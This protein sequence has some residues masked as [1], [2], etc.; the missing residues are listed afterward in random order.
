MADYFTEYSSFVGAKG[1]PS[2]V[3]TPYETPNYVRSKRSSRA[4]ASSSREQ[5]SSPPPLPTDSTDL[6][7]KTRDGRYT[8]LDPR[9]FTPTLHASLVSEILNLRR[10]LDSKNNLVENLE[11]DLS[12]ARNENE[13]LNG[14][15]SE[16]TKEIRRAKHQVQQMEQG[17]YDAVEV[18][19]RERDN[20]LVALEEL[21][22]KLEFA[23]RKTKQQDEDAER[24]QNIWE[25]DKESW[26]NERRQ[27]ERRIHVTESRLRAV[28]DEMS[29]QQSQ[30]QTDQFADDLVFKDS[31]LGEGSDTASI[32]SFNSPVKHKRNMSSISYRPRNGR[33]SV[34]SRTTAATPDL[35]A[36]PGGTLADELGID[37]EEE[38]ELENDGSEQGD[39]DLDVAEG[40]KRTLRSRQSSVAGDGDLD[41]KSKRDLGLRTDSQ[42]TPAAQDLPKASSETQDLQGPTKKYLDRAT[43]PPPAGFDVTA[44]APRAAYVDSGYQPSPPASPPRV[45]V[46]HAGD[47]KAESDES[48]ANDEMRPPAIDTSGLQ[49]PR[50]EIPTKPISPP[51]TPVV[52]GTTW[53]HEKAAFLVALPY[54]TASTQTDLVEPEK[55]QTGH[56]SKRD[57]LSPPMFVPSIAIIPPS[58]RPSS[59]RPYVLP[60]G[61]K[62]AFSQANLVWPSKD[63]CAQTEEIRIDKRPV[64]LPPHLL[65]GA[66]LPS[67]TF[68]EQARGKALVMGRTASL[69]NKRKSPPAIIIPA[70]PPLQS[71]I[72]SSPEMS[73]NNSAKDLRSYPLKALPLPRPVLSPLLPPIESFTSNGPLNRSS[74]YGVTQSR[75]ELHQHTDADQSSDGSDDEFREEHSMDVIPA[76]SRPPLGRFGLSDPPKAVPE[77]KEISPERRPSTADSYGAAPAPSIS[78]SRAAS[79]RRPARQSAMGSKPNGNRDFRSRSPSFGSM[80]SSHSAH[81]VMP[82]PP[83]PV[84]LRTSS[85]IVGKPLSEGSQSPTPYD[86][87]SRGGRSGRMNPT[88]QVSLRKVQSAAVMRNRTGRGSPTKDRFGRASPTRRSSPSKGYRRQRRS[89]DLTPVQS[90]AFE[91][92]AP[93]KFPIPELPTPLQDSLSYNHVNGSVDMTRSP[94]RNSGARVSEETNLVDAIAGTMV[95]EWMWKYIRKRKSFG[96]SDDTSEFPVA[97]QNGIVSNTGHGTRH[98]RWVWLSPYERTIMWDTKQ[99]NSGAALLGKKGRKRKIPQCAIILRVY[100]NHFQLPFNLCSMWKTVP[101]CPRMQSLQLLGIAPS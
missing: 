55:P 87:F 10:E 54:S 76:L 78:S 41:A 80:G 49:Q 12:V 35:Y 83:F 29:L 37:E 91:S 3:D 62:N 40:A 89:P 57:S 28:V 93:T 43:T 69:F 17:T 52:D 27:L 6:Q 39:E 23:Q 68:Q 13:A 5:S 60:P 67:P 34:S 98:K 56:T 42:D 24:T 32:R 85:R 33:T 61:T 95:G 63:A 59:P 7:D 77:D 47:D 16:N 97:D 101:H 84:P 74:Q 73:R 86:N 46:T 94:G 1:M 66:L 72:E 65:P 36:R 90:L 25:N 70:S 21:R 8:G 31:G 75:I 96:I 19:A 99:P 18:L 88:R 15:L 48:D 82:M 2:P 9:R 11:S 79:Q 22:S 64:K 50:R 58:S 51:Q 14:Q 30:L 53:L 92:P 45:E 44:P 71:P 81:S 20:A 100:A 38:A 26:D 4:T